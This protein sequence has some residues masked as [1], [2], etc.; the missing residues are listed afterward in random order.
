MF[1]EWVTDGAAFGFKAFFALAVFLLCC[2]AVLGIMAV[3]SHV[4]R[5]DDDERRAD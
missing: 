1:Y 5:G 4:V 3:L 2:G